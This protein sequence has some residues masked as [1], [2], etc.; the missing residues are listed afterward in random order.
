MHMEAASV[1]VKTCLAAAGFACLVGFPGAAAAAQSTSDRAVLEALYDATGGANWTDNTNWKTSAPLDEWYGVT[2]DADGRVTELD[3]YDNGLSGPLPFELAGLTNLER[4]NLDFNELTGLVPRWLGSLSQLRELDLSGSWESPGLTGPIPAELGGL[5]NLESLNLEGNALTGRIPVELGE[6]TNLERLA[7][8]RNALTGPVPVWLGN[9]PRLRYL[10]LSSNE[11]TGPIPAEL[12]S[13]ANLVNLYLSQNKLTDPIPRELGDLKNLRYLALRANALTGR[14]PREL[15]NLTSLRTLDLSHSDLSGPIPAELGNLTSLERL[16]LSY[17]W[18]LSGPLPAGLEQSALEELDIFVTRTC[19]PAAWKEWLATIDF[20]GPSCDAEPNATIDVAVVYT[21]AAR[22]AAGGSTGIEAEIDL[23]IAETNEAYA[24]SGVRQRLAL[25]GRSEAAYEEAGPIDLDRLADPEDDFLD[26]AHALRDR[27][28]ADMV[29][30][31]VGDPDYWVCGVAFLPGLGWPGPFGITSFDC[32]GIVFAHELGHNL[33]LLHDR[34]RVQIAEDRVLPHPAYGYVNQEM[35]RAGAPASS[36]WATIMAYEWFQCGLTDARCSHV[37]RFSNPHQHYDGDPLGVAFGAGSGVIGAADA[38]AVLNATGPA[39]AA[40]RDR[41][42]RAP[43]AAETLPDRRLT[44][45]GTLTVDVSPAFDDPDG[46]PLIYAAS[47]SAP[48]VAT[49]RSGGSPLDADGG[50]R[51]HGGDPGDG[52][53]PR[54]PERRAAVRGEGRRGAGA[55]HRRPPANRGD[56]DQGGPLHGAADA[57]RRPSDSGGAG[58][59]PLDRPGTAARGDTGEARASAGASEGDRRRVLGGGTAGAAVDR[60]R[61][62]G[63]DA[64]PGGAP[65]GAARRGGGVGMRRLGRGRSG[66]RRPE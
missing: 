47:S 46:D 43:V 27:T 14:I 40:W 19:A 52:D 29:H 18:G 26:E 35:F 13:L 60:C 53:R 1:R 39:A 9:L 50:E 4:L 2:T 56:A 58:T 31:I 3:L 62:C 38:A 48:G 7:L 45:D 41:P 24:T 25:V 16:N 30:L 33:G 51:G 6:L 11:L 57:D 42:N 61:S 20:L 63:S 64:N 32:G 12:G 15:G 44:L 23:W 10:N 59:V 34:F 65:D 36:R 54:R 28:G 5:P 21:P 17:A 22:E 55:V 37:P 49:V 8:Q 66:V